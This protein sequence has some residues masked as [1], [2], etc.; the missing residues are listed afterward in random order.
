M[1]PGEYR[2]FGTGSLVAIGRRLPVVKWRPTS[3]DPTNLTGLAWLKAIIA[4]M[5]ES[6]STEE[7]AKKRQRVEVEADSL[8]S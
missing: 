5:E 3:N 7:T 6:Q 2:E 4:S 8:G 1:A